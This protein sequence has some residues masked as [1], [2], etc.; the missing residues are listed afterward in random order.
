MTSFLRLY[1][2]AAIVAL[3]VTTAKAAPLHLPPY[4]ARIVPG[5]VVS[6]TE[7]VFQ[8]ANNFDAGIDSYY[9]N[10]TDRRWTR[11]GAGGLV[12][13]VWSPEQDVYFNSA[14]PKN[15]L[16]LATPWAFAGCLVLVPVV[17]ASCQASATAAVHRAQAACQRA[18]RTMQINDSGVCGQQMRTSCIIST[19]ITFSEP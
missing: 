11:S 1:F 3:G 4:E 2:L 19:R 9:V 8:V 17:W 5:Y 14:N 15:V 18:G 10:F 12:S 13:G 7:M 6:H 16:C